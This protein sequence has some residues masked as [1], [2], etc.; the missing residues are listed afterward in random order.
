VLR[1]LIISALS[2]VAVIAA[3][4]TAFGATS[5]GSK[6]I[7]LTCQKCE[8]VGDKNNAFEQSRYNVAQAFNKKYAGKYHMNIQHWGASG[9]G[10]VQYWKRLALA[11]KLPDIFVEGSPVLKALQQSGALLNL[12]PFLAKDKAWKNSFLPG[13]FTSLTYKGQILGIPETR[14][15]IGIF[16]NKHL[17]QKAGITDGFPTTWAKFLSDCA[18]LKAAG[19][20]PIAFDGDWTTLLT[21]ADLIGTQPGGA[22]FLYSGITKG[23]YASN[24]IVVKATEFL[25][26][27]HTSG[28]AN[29]DAFTGDYQNAAT[30]FLQ[31]QAAMI[32][33][34]PWMVAGDIKG[35]NAISGLYSQVGYAP[36]PGWTAGGQGAIVMAGGSGWAA[37]ATKDPAKQ[38]AIIA[39][40]KLTTQPNIQ[41]Q[42]TI[43]TGSFWA[44]KLKLTSTQ[45]AKLEPLAYHLSTLSSNLKYQFVHAKASTPQAFTDEWKNDWPA[46]VKGAMST[47]DFLN[48]LSQAVQAAGH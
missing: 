47:T 9:E 5:G 25:K 39:F 6:V 33:N 30:P 24:P 26:Q 31:G 28:Y 36:A 19:V 37:A 8:P 11:H 20:I 17:F 38:Q 35:P 22:Q 46:Y 12:A 10:D 1:R 32:A 15:T 29:A 44:T 21:W 18:K 7:V 14:D 42:R 48:K 41:L 27:L 2:L 34:G 13:S 40:L 43:E 3:A 4:A 45:I 23:N 16:W